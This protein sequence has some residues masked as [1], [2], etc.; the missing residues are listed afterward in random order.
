LDECEPT[1]CRTRFLPE[2][3][4]L[5][6]NTG[7]NLFATSRINDEI[8]NLFIGSLT[9]EIGA[10]DDD[11]ETYLNAQIFLLQSDILDEGIQDKILTEI[12]RAADGM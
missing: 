1:E 7:A 9:L 11:I 2:L 8:S 3:F 6:A 12:I 5:Q 10:I 4:R